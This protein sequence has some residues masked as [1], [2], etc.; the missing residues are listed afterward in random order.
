MEFAED[1]GV[2]IVWKK[3]FML[4]EILRCYGNAA[5]LLSC[6]AVAKIINPKH[7]IKGQTHIKTFS[8]IKTSPGV[9][10]ESLFARELFLGGKVWH[11]WHLFGCVTF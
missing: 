7:L 1:D 8:V 6:S 11:C 5:S 9:E 3:V 10:A 2:E 4:L